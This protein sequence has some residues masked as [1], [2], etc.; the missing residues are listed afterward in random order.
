MKKNIL[1][2]A[3]RVLVAL[4]S[5]AFLALPIASSALQELPSVETN[6]ANTR[7]PPAF[8]G[9][10]RAPGIKTQAAYEHEV[11]AQGLA[12]PWGLALMPDGRMLITQKSGT[13][14]IASTDGNLS[15]PIDGFSSIAD[16]GQGGLLDLVLSP[17]FDQSRLIFFTFSERA[18][19][20]SVTALGRARL[21]EEEGRV[22]DFNVIYRALPY[23]N[24]SGHF[25]SR[26][27]IDSEGLIYLSTGDRQ[28]N[29][30]RPNAQTSD[31]GHGKILRLTQDGQPAP[32]NP[33][34]NQAGA[35]PELYS[36]GHRNVQGMD[37]DPATGDVWISEMGPR[38]GDELNLIRPGLNYGWPA[39]SYGI[40]YSG[41]RI[42][43]GNTQQEGM[44]QPVYYWDPVIAPSGMAFY[45][46]DAIPEWQGNLFIGALAG[47][48]ISRLVIHDGQVMYEE[49]LLEG[50]YQR[51]RDVLS[52]PDG[53]LYGVTDEGRL[54][55]IGP[56]R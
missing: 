33:F 38:G 42:G 46:S 7:Y 41:A 14:R 12:N 31:N 43:P 55:R 47:Q 37:I 19:G 44:E 1:T 54:H 40:E 18:Q 23:H 13:L 50:E 32:N 3:P 28:S 27:V 56:V 49:R 36:L 6:R 10:T 52:H 24:G 9:Q 53:S 15:E 48:H 22:E 34:L 21:N 30:T 39:I 20:G 4:F 25:G 17:D 16:E 8:S 2:F 26:L 5:V 45:T 29:S 51:I 11:I 35:I